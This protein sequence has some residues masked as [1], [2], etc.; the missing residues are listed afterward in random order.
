MRFHFVNP[1]QVQTPPGTFLCPDGVVAIDD[2]ELTKL[3]KVEPY[4]KDEGSAGELA[5]TSRW[6]PQAGGWIPLTRFKEWAEEPAATAKEEAA[7]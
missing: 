7:A 5:A 4:V 1:E 6:F 2:P 3:I